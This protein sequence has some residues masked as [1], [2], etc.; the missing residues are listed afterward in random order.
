MVVSVPS[1]FAASTRAD[2]A[3]DPPPPPPEEAGACVALGAHAAN[4]ETTS[5]HEKTWNNNVLVFILLFSF[6]NCASA[7][8]S[9]IVIIYRTHQTM[10]SVCKVLFN[11]SPPPLLHTSGLACP[12]C[13]ASARRGIWTSLQTFYRVQRSVSGLNRV[14]RLLN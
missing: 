2:M 4:M 7:A 6:V 5:S 12:P 9:A 10:L 3:S 13:R 11:V 14:R 1:F 8:R